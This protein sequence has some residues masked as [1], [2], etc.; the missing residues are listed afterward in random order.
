MPLLED[1]N[2][3]AETSN[4]PTLPA[5]QGISLLV[6]DRRVASVINSESVVRKALQH[7]HQVFM[8]TL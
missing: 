4:E 7:L 1:E 3:L 5:L 2:K 6:A 8:Q